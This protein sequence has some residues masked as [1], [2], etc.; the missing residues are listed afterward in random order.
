[1]IDS[2]SPRLRLFFGLSALLAVVNLFIMNDVATVWD[3]AETRLAWTALHDTGKQELP[4]AAVRLFSG[5]T[6]APFWLR[7]PGALLLIL[8]VPVV[9]LVANPVLG[10]TT[11]SWMLLVLGSTFLLPNTA[12]V[13]SADT[14]I[15]AFQLIGLLL[16]IRFMKKPA[17]EWRWFFYLS[18]L[19]AIWTAPLSSLLLFSLMPGLLF[20]LH[21]QGKNMWNLQPWGIMLIIVGGL[22]AAG[23]LD[24]SAGLSH[25]AFRSGRFLL[26]SVLGFL[27][28]VGF[29]AA[30]LIDMVRKVR[31]GEE[32]ALINLSWLIAS[33]L[34]HSLVLQVVFA[35]LVARQ[36][37]LYFRENY[38]FR[39]WVRTLSI[40]HLVGVFF[41]A[42]ALMMGGFV[43]FEGAGF[44][45]GLAVSAPY[46]MASFLSVI[47][48]FG[49]NRRFV[50][51]GTVMS[52]LLA[53]MLFWLQL[54]PLWEQGRDLP[55]KLAREADAMETSSETPFHLWVPGEAYASNEFLYAHQHFS[56]VRTISDTIA[57][58]RSYE[59]G[60]AGVYAVPADM[61]RPGW[62]LNDT[63]IV[64]GLD[65]RF[66]RV[67]WVLFARD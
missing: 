66:Q 49:M 34:S 45:A 8:L 3:G 59:R 24:W 41:L 44:R 11:T 61:T 65:D 46:W 10:K 55:R 51:G 19:F 56:K 14:W 62:K 33:L 4:V 63:L 60:E 40:L 35:L 5:D 39:D 48:L 1:M 37:H 13:A 50:W 38:P 54:Y 6:L 21:P 57:L 30:G 26:L 17:P 47:G 20:R 18:L 12:K 23:A 31:R 25:F 64:E 16:L 53:T 42:T 32:L 52:G 29:L 9:W 7:F 58:A 36:L 43:R 22:Y 15:F 2:F 67:K 28:L 27:P